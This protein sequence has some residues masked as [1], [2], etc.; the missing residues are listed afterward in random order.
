[1]SPS[2][3]PSLVF[4]DLDRH[5]LADASAVH[6]Q[7]HPGGVL[8]LGAVDMDQVAGFDSSTGGW[9]SFTTSIT[10]TPLSSGTW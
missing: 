4:L 3:P 5:R 1:M 6:R 7:L 9:L 2:A 8:N 10:S